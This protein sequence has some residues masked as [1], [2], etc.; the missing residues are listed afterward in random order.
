VVA[1]LERIEQLGTHGVEDP[2]ATFDGEL[3]WKG[4]KVFEW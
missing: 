3:T 1:A 2:A 4:V